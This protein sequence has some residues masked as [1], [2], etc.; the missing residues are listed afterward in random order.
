M[1]VSDYRNVEAGL[2]QPGRPGC[3]RHPGAPARHRRRAR[4]RD[5][6]QRRAAPGLRQR[7]QR[8][9]QCL[10]RLVRLQRQQ[11]PRAGAST[12][13]TPGAAATRAS[14]S[15][16]RDQMP[17][18]NLKN[19]TV[20]S[21]HQDNLRFWLN[22]G[23]DGFRFDAVGNLG[24][25]RA[26]CVGEPA[27]EL[28]ADGQHP[29]HGRRQLCEPL[30]GLRRAVGTARVRHG[31]WQRLRLRP[32]IR[33]DQ[34]SQ[35]AMPQPSPA[36]RTTSAPHRPP[37][38]PCCPTTTASP[39]IGRWIQFNGNETQY[40]L[41]AATYLL[42][43][44]TPFIY[45]GEE[46]GMRGGNLSGDPKL[47]TPMSGPAATPARAAFT[48]GTPFRALARAT[49]RRTTCRPA[50]RPGHSLFNW[51]KAVIAARQPGHA[52]LPAA[53]RGGDDQRAPPPG[54]RHHASASI[55]RPVAASIA[56]PAT[57]PRPWCHRRGQALTGRRRRRRSRV[58]CMIR[59]AIRQMHDREDRAAHADQRHHGED[60]DGRTASPQAAAA[61]DEEG[62]QRRPTIAV[63][64]ARS[65]GGR[66]I[67]RP[68]RDGRTS[69]VRQ[70]EIARTGRQAGEAGSWAMN[71]S[72]R[73]CGRWAA[74]CH[75][76]NGERCDER[77]RGRRHVSRGEAP[78]PPAPEGIRM[79]EAQ[80][81][82]EGVGHVGAAGGDEL[83]FHGARAA[84][85]AGQRTS[86]YVHRV[87]AGALDGH[88]AVA[89]A[90]HGVLHRLLAD[91]ARLALVDVADAA[92]EKSAAGSRR[93]R[94]ARA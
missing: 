61:A 45:Y 79:P 18:F 90:P 39:A 92:D 87:E 16:L 76:P 86:S 27:G 37:C 38:R 74:S 25:E 48:T 32:S 5:E 35:R 11:A 56:H 94:R 36:W 84:G 64:H 4:L 31:L 21:W 7:Q 1:R 19:A 72:R 51:Y 22:R 52:A 83:V 50:G 34:R 41:A 77:T 17:D 82:P 13:A 93:C 62:R 43:P 58:R 69:A 3:P 29:R 59:R 9:R 10:P 68:Q 30:P 78:C 54:H 65:R 57:R 89:L 8:Q 24:R 20:V 73:R 15:P 63:T 67:P 46:I 80:V 47:R 28:H 75:P 81:E 40:R 26:E 12:A 14:T 88:R 33:S 49:W 42:Q 60:V 23:V 66:A 55:P 6:P 44:G 85:H 70:G 71:F 91:L 53:A 2:R